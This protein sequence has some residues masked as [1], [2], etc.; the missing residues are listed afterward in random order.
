MRTGRRYGPLVARTEVELRVL[1]EFDVRVNGASAVP[2]WPTRRSAELV[3]LLAVSP[4][5]RLLRDE[6]I[7]ALWPALPAD[8]GGANLRKAAH[9]ARRALGDDRAVVL[10]Q[11]Q[12]LLYPDA[13]IRD[14]RTEFLADAQIA[15]DAGDPALAA[16]AVETY[17]GAP[18]PAARYEAWAEPV[19]AT[20]AARY[21]D[22]LRLAARWDLL[23]EVDP[24]DEPAC[25]AL[26]QAALADG[27]PHRAL[28]H[29]G[30]LSTALRELGVPPSPR[31]EQAHAACRAVLRP[32]RHPPVGRDVELARFDEALTSP[33]TRSDLV[34]VRGI[35]GIGKTSLL[36]ELA[37]R[38]AERGWVTAATTAEDP[39]DAGATLGALLATLLHGRAGLLRSLDERT[40]A[41]LNR[42]VPIPGALPTLELPVTRHQLVGAVQRLIEV[43]GARRG[44]L[45]LVDDLERCDE[46]TLDVLALLGDL[47]AGR[48]VV[49]LA[50]RTPSPPLAVQ[51]ALSRAARFQPPVVLEL[52][53]LN[54]TSA[55]D[56]A[57]TTAADLTEKQL[58]AVVARADGV[59][60]FLVELAGSAGTVGSDDAVSDA[61]AARLLDLASHDVA[62]LRRL[63][64]GEGVLDLDD[65]QALTG[66]AEHETDLLLDRGLEAGVLVVEETGYRF[67]HELVRTLLAGQV[68]PHHRAAAHRE[69]ARRL[70]AAGARPGRVAV[71]WTLGRRPA[72]A[73]RSFSLASSDAV[74]VGGF[75]DALASAD[76]ALA[77]DPSHAGAR[78]LRAAA[79]DALGDPRA[80]AAYDAAMATASTAEAVELQPLQALAQIKMG[81]PVGALATI[82]G[83]A[84]VSMDSQLAHALTLSGA[85]LL[86]AVGPEEGTRLSAAGRERSLRAGDRGA[87][88]VAAWAQAAVAHARGDLRDSLLRDLHDTSA[89]P[90]LAVTVFDGQLCITQR[91]LYGNRP[92]DEV[93]AYADAFVA[94]ADRLGAARG[95]AFATTLRGE[96]ALL[97]GQLERAARDLTDGAR[98][99][100]E[101]GAATGESF[102]LQRLAELAQL[103]GENTRAR[104]LLDESLRVARCSDVGFHLLDRIYGTRISLARDPA[105]AHAALLEAEQAVRGPYETCPGCRITLE[106]PA[107]IAAARS[108]DL[109]RLEAYEKSVTWLAEV[110]MRLPAWDAALHEVRAHRSLAQ[111][112]DPGAEVLFDR[113]A[114]DFDRA[115]QPLDATRCTGEAARLRRGRTAPTRSRRGPGS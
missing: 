112:D 33:S 97:S 96:A 49:V 4:G 45:L 5:H 18:L 110:V 27:R 91:L 93:I 9:H 14:D 15:L 106:V 28:A 44:V 38:A 21:V 100:R 6:A 69:A 94:E 75:A 22:L 37:A 66:T 20:V 16:R 115:G 48:L 86:G 52:G 114:R 83:A 108:G 35:A 88:V 56:V 1:G 60:L 43:A 103:Q 12:V 26:M 107:A 64:L 79:L 76:R 105:E 36:R 63:A 8:A 71:H 42:V 92:Y 25:L 85:A 65:V 7:D 54:A 10:H 34:V 101:I 59:P 58:G 62:L 80:L 111:G 46:A 39:H 90:R 11:Q 3:Q 57:R 68:P 87:V 78:Q 104:E 30:R 50:H 23:A 17:R 84:P 13:V 72:E 73:A 2:D 81:D 19:R 24:T 77:C 32:V 51:R 53:P 95:V 98:L 89:L 99:H 109:A 47:P 41:V 55:A 61:L 67:R 82:A 113:A 31:V 102:S 29:H 40:L 70:E 74:R